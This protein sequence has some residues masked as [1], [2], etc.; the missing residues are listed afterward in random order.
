[1]ELLE[2][3][4]LTYTNPGETVLDNCMGAGSA[5]VACMNTGRDFIGME[6]DLEY[7]RI[8]KYRIE[9]HEI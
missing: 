5:G 3:L 4:I 2:Y 7:Y 1:V 6:L 8:A 9:K